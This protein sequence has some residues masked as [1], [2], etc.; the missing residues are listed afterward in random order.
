MENDK[1]KIRMVDD[2]GHFYLNGKLYKLQK[3]ARFKGGGTKR[4]FEGVFVEVNPEEYDKRIS[5]LTERVMAYPGVVLSDII[6]DALYDLQ[7]NVLENLEK[8][9]DKEDMKAA[10]KG[11]TPK[12]ETKRGDRGTC[13][14]L[15][16]GGRYAAQLR[17]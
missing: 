3:Y 9:L 1:V 15:H 16:I 17:I 13:V 10:E 12:V 6:K 4:T 11:Q 5:A 2:Q 7:L 8:R 14:E